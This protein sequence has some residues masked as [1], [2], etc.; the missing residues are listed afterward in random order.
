MFVTGISSNRICEQKIL[1]VVE[2]RRRVKGGVCV[3]GGGG[4]CGSGRGKG[5]K[6]VMFCK[7][8]NI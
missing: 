4:Y 1:P 3:W 6:G 7:Q 2:D 8:F 5:E